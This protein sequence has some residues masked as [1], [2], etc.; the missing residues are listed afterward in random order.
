MAEKTKFFTKKKKFLSR[1]CLFELSGINKSRQ[2]GQVP[3]PKVGVKMSKVGVMGFRPK[4]HVFGPILTFLDSKYPFSRVLSSF[5]AKKP[6]LIL[7]K[8]A[9]TAIEVKQQRSQGKLLKL[10][11]LSNFDVL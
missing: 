11:F 6:H 7:P 3:R 10:Q 5:L 9:K 4:I 1:G 8:T 2:T